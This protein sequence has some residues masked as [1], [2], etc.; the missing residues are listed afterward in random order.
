MERKALGKGLESLLSE[1]YA[2]SKY[3]LL[4]L[5]VDNLVA[6]IGIQYFGK[7]TRL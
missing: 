5:D 3:V 4:E 1:D 6:E 7:F 2:P